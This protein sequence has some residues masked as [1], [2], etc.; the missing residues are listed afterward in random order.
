MSVTS[1][2]LNFSFSSCQI[3]A[4]CGTACTACSLI[5]LLE[6]IDDDC[7]VFYLCLYCMDI[8]Y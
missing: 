1:S 4:F 8:V 6:I 3:V 5:M 7:S 2:H